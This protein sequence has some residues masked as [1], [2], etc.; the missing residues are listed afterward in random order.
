M[1]QFFVCLAAGPLDLRMTLEAL[2][3]VRH[4]TDKHCGARLLCLAACGTRPA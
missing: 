3:P 4:P 1:W 2:L